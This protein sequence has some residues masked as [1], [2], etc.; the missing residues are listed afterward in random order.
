MSDTSDNKHELDSYK[1]FADLQI[2]LR[3]RGLR[4]LY[5][6]ILDVQKGLHAL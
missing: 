4:I 2:A 6:P 3:E 1:L 5:Q